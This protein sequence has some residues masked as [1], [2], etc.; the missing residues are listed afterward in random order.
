[1]L[2]NCFWCLSNV[3]VLVNYCWCLSTVAGACKLLLESPF[4][5]TVLT[6]P[7]D[8]RIGLSF[9]TISLDWPFGPSPWTVPL[10]NWTIAFDRPLWTVP[11]RPSPLDDPFGRP[12]WTA[13]LYH[14]F[15]P[16]DPPFGPSLWPLPLDHSFGQSS[17][18]HCTFGQ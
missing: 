2:V 15:E 18:D 9:W 12:L 16:L 8:R 4:R 11:F 10:H 3:L 5:P 7:L 6:V 17:L 1:M 14:P 13:P